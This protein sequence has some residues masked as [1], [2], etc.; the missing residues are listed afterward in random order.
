MSDEADNTAP[1]A[2]AS[3]A[4]E[5]LAYLCAHVDEISALLAHD[6]AGREALERLRS[7]LLAAGDISGPLD[8]IHDAVLRAGDAAARP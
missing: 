6:A 7:G 8:D 4:I 1:Q 3:R 5:G 2:A